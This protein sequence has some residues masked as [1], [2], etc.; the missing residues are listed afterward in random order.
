MEI[1]G[2]EW[3]KERAANEE[4]IRVAEGLSEIARSINVSLP[5]MAIAWCLKNSN[6]STVILGA[7]KVA[8]LEENLTAI[9][10]KEKLTDEVLER[11]E[12][13]LDNKP[14]HPVF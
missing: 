10:A 13:C 5:V 1:E 11:I 4:N 6:V 2:L 14:V 9:E 12:D 7:S 8:Q 3:L